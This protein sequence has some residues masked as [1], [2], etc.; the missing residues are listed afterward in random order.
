MFFQT[1]Y[2][3]VGK[4]GFEDGGSYRPDIVK[5]RVRRHC[6]GGFSFLLHIPVYMNKTVRGES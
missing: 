2:A 1:N 5:E 6:L 3:R 4:F